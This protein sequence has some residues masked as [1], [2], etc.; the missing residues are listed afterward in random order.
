GHGRVLLDE[1]REPDLD[2]RRLG[3]VVLAQFGAERAELADVD[4]APVPV[5]EL[6]EPAHVR[7]APAVRDGYADVD[8]GDGVLLAALAVEDA[9]RVAQTF[10][11]GAIEREPARVALGMDVA[12]RRNPH[13]SNSPR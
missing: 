3:V 5:Q 12:Q 13:T 10:D 2:V 7:A 6:D 9:D 1:V 11:A 8:L 4:L